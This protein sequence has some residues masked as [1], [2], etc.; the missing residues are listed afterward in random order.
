M[1]TKLRP[2]EAVVIFG[3]FQVGIT[4]L[5]LT[6]PAGELRR[7]AWGLARLAE[8]FDMP[9]LAMSIP[10]A[11]GGNA[12]IIPEITR[13]RTRYQQFLRTTPDS[14]EHEAFRKA[15]EKTG[16][17]TLIVCGIATEICLHWLVL[18]GIANGYRVYVVVD[19]CGGLSARSEQAAFR[20]FEAAGAVMSSVVSLAGE[21]AGDFVSSPAGGDAIAVVY[22]MIGPAGAS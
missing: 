9:T 14:F 11:G 3:D 2:D 5:P 20:R 6:V 18:S 16:R 17:K 13:T 12:E 22:R 15:I 21:L 19:A 8:V 1:Q 4:E 7:S 10:K